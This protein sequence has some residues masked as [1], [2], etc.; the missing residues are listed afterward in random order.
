MTFKWVTQMA[1][2]PSGIFSAA[3][4]TGPATA[5]AAPRRINSHKITIS[6]RSNPK[7]IKPDPGKE[8][9]RLVVAAA[10][11]NSA[12]QHSRRRRTA[13]IY[14]TT[15]PALWLPRSHVSLSH[16]LIP[17]NPKGI[18]TCPGIAS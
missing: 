9:I 16:S 2:P 11:T 1:T 3:D 4:T 13:L 5:K 10:D 12:L 14:L 17:L 15:A 8:P 7:G 6:F 18:K